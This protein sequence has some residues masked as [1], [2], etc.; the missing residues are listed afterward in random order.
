METT[1]LMASA[2]DVAKPICSQSG[3]VEGIIAGIVISGIVGLMVA[4]FLHKPTGSR[5]I[6]S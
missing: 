6:R 4:G 5:R 2:S 3:Y 1:M